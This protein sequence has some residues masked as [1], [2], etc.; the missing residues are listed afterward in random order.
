[1]RRSRPIAAGAPPAAAARAAARRTN[2]RAPLRPKQ[3]TG[4]PTRP[5]H[6]RAPPA[7]PRPCRMRAYHAHAAAPIGLCGAYMLR[8]RRCGARNGGGRAPTG[9][10]A[11]CSRRQ[12]WFPGDR[13]TPA[14]GCKCGLSKEYS[15]PPGRPRG[16]GRGREGAAP[17]AAGGAARLRARRGVDSAG[18]PPPPARRGRGMWSGAARRQRPGRARRAR[19]ALTCRRCRPRRAPAARAPPR[20]P[21][22]CRRSC[23]RR[24]RRRRRCRSPRRP[25]RHS[26]CPAW[27]RGQ[28]A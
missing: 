8:R 22:R 23:P 6:K 16:A 7:P 9:R 11:N 17:G 19:G 20:A 4:G 28:R 26:T 2:A 1:M 5:P 25:R 27:A 21:R 13:H 12:F 24:R 15:A 10:A 18:P 14:L 3:T